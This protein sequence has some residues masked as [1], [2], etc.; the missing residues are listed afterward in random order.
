MHGNGPRWTVGNNLEERSKK[1]GWR[2]GAW[3][4]ATLLV[5]AASGAVGTGEASGGWTVNN[6]VGELSTKVGW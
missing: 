3:V 6:K 4:P 1:V 2:K 5:G